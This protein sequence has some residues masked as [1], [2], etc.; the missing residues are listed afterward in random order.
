MNIQIDKIE[1]LKIHKINQNNVIVENNLNQKGIIHIAD[2]S[3]S[4]IVS[5]ENEFNIGD[6]VYG[7][8]TKTDDFRRFYS[9]KIG[10]NN[11]KKSQYTESGGGI[12]GIYFLLN[13][14]EKKE[15]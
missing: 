2:I 11:P 4:F 12:L 15:Q 8:L 10:H 3:N 5:L 13:K 6:I 1:K 9:L 7:Y 14:L